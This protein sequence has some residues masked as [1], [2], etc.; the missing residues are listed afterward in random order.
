MNHSP[1]IPIPRT[2]VT[3]RKIFSKPDFLPAK[4]LHAAPIQNRV[5]PFSFA[6][7]AASSTG[8][9]STRREALVGVL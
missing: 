2:S 4:S 1:S 5:D 7:R 8:S 6:F 9:T 3:I